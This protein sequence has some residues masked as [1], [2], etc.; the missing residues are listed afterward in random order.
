VD[1]GKV[2]AEK[3][4]V[5]LKLTEND[6]MA[7]SAGFNLDSLLEDLNQATKGDVEPATIKFIPHR[8]AK[9]KSPSQVTMP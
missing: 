7:D 5:V 3:D 9:E 6:G 2:F 1:L 4:S 8:P